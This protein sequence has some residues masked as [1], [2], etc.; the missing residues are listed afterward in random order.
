MPEHIYPLQPGFVRVINPM[1]TISLE[2]PV[3][4]GDDIP[5]TSITEN[6]KCAAGEIYD[7]NDYPFELHFKAG[8]CAGLLH[9][10]EQLR[11]RREAQRGFFDFELFGA[12][13][14]DQEREACGVDATTP[15]LL[16]ETHAPKES[17]SKPATSTTR[18]STLPAPL[19]FLADSEDLQQ[20]WC[21]ALRARVLH[22]RLREVY[23]K[24]QTIM[25]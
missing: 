1:A 14:Q 20:R 21:R 3:A 10:H 15:G 9:A 18:T 16:V 23:M 4:T 25:V 5:Q 7:E 11:S 13:D 2:R 8:A 12:L 24:I 22:P 6:V 19:C 17:Y